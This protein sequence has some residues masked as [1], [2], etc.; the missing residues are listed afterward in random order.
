MDKVNLT[1][2]IIALKESLIE[3]TPLH[4]NLIKYDVND[5]DDVLIRTERYIRLEGIQKAGLHP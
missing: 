5:I 2:A 3:D 1:L 4:W